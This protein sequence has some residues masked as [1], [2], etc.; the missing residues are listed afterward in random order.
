LNGTKVGFTF[1]I[2]LRSRQVVKNTEPT[3]AWETL[4]VVKFAFTYET[5]SLRSLGGRSFR[6]RMKTGNPVTMPI[7]SKSLSGLYARF[8]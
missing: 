5:N 2:E 7:G 1:R 8:G 3:P 4:S 6:P